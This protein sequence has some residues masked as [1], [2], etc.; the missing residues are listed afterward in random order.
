M[1]TPYSKV[2]LETEAV[3]HG[4]AWNITSIDH[5]VPTA[6]KCFKVATFYTDQNV[7]PLCRACKMKFGGLREDASNH[8]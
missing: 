7:I 6:S 2:I 8:F 1:P 4:K 3:R 5:A